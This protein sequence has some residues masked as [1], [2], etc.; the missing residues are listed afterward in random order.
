MYSKRSIRWLIVFSLLA[1]LS[2][3]LISNRAPN[4][5]HPKTKLYQYNPFSWPTRVENYDFKT[6]LS[7]RECYDGSTTRY[8]GA[9]MTESI[10]KTVHFTWGLK[11]DGAFNF[12]FYLAIKAALQS[13]QPTEVK[14]HY[15]NL[16]RSNEYFKEL[17]GN[18]TLVHHDPKDYF[19]K[20]GFAQDFDIG[21]WHVAHV[22]D[23]LR[24][25]ILQEEGGIY[26]DSDAYALHSFDTIVA[27]ARDVFM[28]HEGGNR[29]GMANAVIVAKAN[30][31]FINRW[32]KAYTQNFDRNDWN[33]NS[34]VLPK[35]LATE[36]PNE[37]CTLSPTAFFW[38][39][40]TESQIEYMHEPLGAE[41]ALQMEERV[42]RLE[43]RLYEDQ[44]VYHAWSQNSMS[45][46]INHLT[47][48]RIRTENTR[49]NI[50]LRRFLD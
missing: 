8:N 45:L 27:G 25:L 12:P 31:P 10:P 21:S 16:D 24:L 18:I 15:T 39:L 48:E 41:M 34:V 13:I 43:G 28:A 7:E 42:E 40:W 22:A 6:T 46:Y 37:I 1:I 3:L 19:S 29:Y 49:F 20:A 4:D 26:L 36:Y 50:L 33:G 11:G 30:A 5:E 47:P 38:P 23:V 35:R 2:F 9:G 32:L 14:V 44:L 17:E